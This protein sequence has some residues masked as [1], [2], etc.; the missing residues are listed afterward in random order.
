MMSFVRAVK[1]SPNRS[2]VPHLGLLGLI[3]FIPG[4]LNLY[5]RAGSIRQPDLLIVV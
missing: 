5:I 3:K 1:S 2:L 4:L